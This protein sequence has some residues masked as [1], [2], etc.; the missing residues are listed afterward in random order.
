MNLVTNLQPTKQV[1]PAIGSLDDP[2][3]SPE[4]QIAFALH[5]LLAAR[6]D[7]REVAA[8]LGRPTQLRIV[9]ALVAAEM[10]ARCLLGRR[11]PDDHGV[12]SGT[13]HLH[14][15]PVRARERDRQWDAVGVRE[16]VPLGAQFPAIGRVFS[17]LVPPLTGAETV[18]ESRDW[19]R[20]SIPWR[21]S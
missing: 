10:L 3:T 19:K 4:S 17:G 12:E 8:T 13:E 1:V 15:V 16:I 7:M 6:F 18:A 20:Q 9:V 21:L 14:V 2:S 11:S 5:F